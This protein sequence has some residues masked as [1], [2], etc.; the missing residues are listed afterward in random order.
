MVFGQR[1]HAL[2]ALL[3]GNLLLQLVDGVVTHIGV[4]AGFPEGNPLVARV[5]D[6]LGLVPGLV[7]LKIQAC[8]CLGLIWALRHR[9]V[10]AAP[11][12]AVSATVY[13]ALS[14]GPW[15]ALLAPTYLALLS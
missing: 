1:E 13:L 10:L 6:H 12:L 11:A 3:L 9:S 14:I 4:S 7:V 5:I 2:G 15:T 8:A